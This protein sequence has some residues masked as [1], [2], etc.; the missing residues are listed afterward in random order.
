MRRLKF[1]RQRE[2]FGT[3]DLGPVP[4]HPRRIHYHLPEIDKDIFSDLFYL[5]V[6]IIGA[7][8]VPG[9]IPGV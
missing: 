2:K 3:L 9:A 4:K 1:V 8:V 6:Q 5:P 7:C